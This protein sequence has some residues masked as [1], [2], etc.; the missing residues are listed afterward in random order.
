MT[1]QGP[2]VGEITVPSDMSCLQEVCKVVLD[3]L[4]RYSFGEEDV[5]AVHLALEEA[6]S[7][8]VEHGNRRNPQKTVHLKYT[9]DQEK[10]ELMLTDQGNGFDPSHVPDPRLEPN[11]NDARG[12]GLLLIR[13][14]MDEVDFSPKGNSVRMVR[15]RHPESYSNGV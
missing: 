8:A 9:I 10:V 2:T 4:A 11:I 14:Y 3:L 7:N 1:S 5:F 12:R 6:F 15:F 13:A